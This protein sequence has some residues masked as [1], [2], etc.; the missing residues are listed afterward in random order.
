MNRII[1]SAIAILMLMMNGCGKPELSREMAEKIL[2][3]SDKLEKTKSY[4]KILNYEK[5]VSDSKRYGIRVDQWQQKILSGQ[6]LLEHAVRIEEKHFKL[7]RPA[8]FTVTVTGIKKDGENSRIAEFHWKQ[9]NLPSIIKNYS[10]NGG[11]GVAKF[12]LF[13]DGWRLSKVALTDS[14]S[15]IELSSFEKNELDKLSERIKQ[16]QLEVAR[17]AQDVRKKR[18]ERLQL[19]TRES[20]T[21]FSE[22]VEWRSYG[23][24]RRGK[25]TISDA[26]V[27]FLN[28]FGVQQRVWF[29]NIKNIQ[30]SVH[31]NNYLHLTFFCGIKSD[32][33]SSSRTRESN[34]LIPIGLKEKFSAAYNSAFN[35]WKNA[36]AEF[37][38]GSWYRL[39]YGQ[40]CS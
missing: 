18:D 3:A 34:A 13:D 28:Q 37:Y 7:V 21:L 9:V 4:A 27:T 40:E 30:G 2:T 33:Y 15:P 10:A 35:H 20:K 14:N 19:A 6:A 29:G 32:P 39:Q 8:G 25:L 17:A 31:G 36:H 1:I 16:E 22:N 23:E 26:Y 38:G 5:F 24:V 11:A 12:E